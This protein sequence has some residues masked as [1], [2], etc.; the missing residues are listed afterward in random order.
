MK[1]KNNKKTVSLALLLLLVV[2]ISIGYASLTSLLTIDGKSSISSQTWDVHFENVANATPSNADVTV[3]KAAAIKELT[4]TPT[5]ETDDKTVE[6]TVS[7]K[8]P[9]DSYTFNVNVVNDGSLPAKAKLTVTG[10]T[11]DAATYLD[12]TVTGVD[13]TD[14]ETIAAGGSK[15]LTVTVGF[16]SGITELPSSAIENVTLSARVDAEQV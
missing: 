8:K 10:L 3:T 9:G 13:T 1:K 12:W 11:G 14:G 16:K 2:S 7:F 4:T 5:D 6:F 15:T